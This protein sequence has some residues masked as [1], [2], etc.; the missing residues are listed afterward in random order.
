MNMVR[1]NQWLVDNELSQLKQS[2]SHEQ[3][4]DIA[5]WID[6]LELSQ[7]MLV[8]RLLNKTQAVDVFPYL[9]TDARWGLSGG[10]GEK[11]LYEVLEKLHLDDMIDML[12]EMPAGVVDRFL[13][14]ASPQQR[15]IINEVLNY[16]KNSAGSIMTVEFMLL[17]REMTV[18]QALERIRSEALD[19]ETIYTCY[20]TDA[21]RRLEGILS[22]KDL[23]TAFP[24]T[25]VETLMIQEIVY[26]TTL[27][28]QAWVVEQIKKYDL[29]AI[30][31]TDQ[32]K[33]LVGIITV[34]D[35]MDIL[36]EEDTEDFYKMATIGDLEDSVLQAPV[37]VLLKKRLPWL[38]ALIFMNLFSGAGIA[39]FQDL[40]EKVISLIFFLPLLIDSAGNAGAQSSTLMIRA[41]AVG[42]VK[43]QDWFKLFQKEMITATLMGLAMAF[44]VSFLGFYRGGMGVSIV[45]SL[46]MLLVVISGSLI[47]MS[48]PFLLR[49]LN[50]DPAAASGPLITSIADISGVL[51]YFTIAAQILK[52]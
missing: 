31:V 40:L 39:H 1:W 26:V 5:A 16:P 29:L 28:D 50:L 20:I 11:E 22:L 19:K 44:C 43:P 51:I 38:T 7:A 2:L 3:P 18:S 10:I 32:E 9:S 14:N 52:L 36:E 15:K 13:K 37:L 17:K 23:V 25:L 21:N 8:F 4:A 12:E 42:D 30:P 27:D 46:T 6:S 49:R 24:G 33:R 34:D 48:L 45:V 35:I 47:G 41:L